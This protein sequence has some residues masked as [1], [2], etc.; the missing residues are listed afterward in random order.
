MADFNFNLWYDSYDPNFTQISKDSL[1]P[2]K[3]ITYQSISQ[4][5][6]KDYILKPINRYVEFLYP[7][8]ELVSI[9]ESTVRLRQRTHAEIFLLENDSGF[10]NIDRPHMRQYYQTKKEYPTSSSCFDPAFLFY[11]PW[12]LDHSCVA[13]FENI[14]GSSFEVYDSTFSYYPVS[15]ETY[16][17]E[18]HLV[19]FRF[20]KVGPHMKSESFGKIKRSSPMFDI[21]IDSDA[22]IIERIRKFY[23]EN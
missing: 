1:I 12:F 9:S 15:S 3:W 18:P 21:V 22:I 5:K 4:D 11:V 20:K 7:K 10:R 17:V 19:P 23:E 13:K 6:Y 8:P 14:E 16:Y 2:E